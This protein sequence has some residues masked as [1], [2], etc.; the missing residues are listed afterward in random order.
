MRVFVTGA[1]GFIGG[2]IARVLAAR[3][4]V[5][6][7]SRSAAGDEVVKKLGAVPVRADLLTLEPGQLPP[8]DAVVH[9]AA[10]VEPW[11]RREDYWRANVDG[12]DRVLAAAKAAGAHRFVHMS[13]EAVLWRG[14]HLRDVIETHPYPKRTPF[15][16]AETKA[17]A[18][19]RVVAA[20]APGFETIVLRPRFVWG[21][22]DRTIV[23]ET[24]AMVERGAFVWL[25]G[26]RARTSTTHVAN[27]A[28]AAALA[29]DKGRAGEIYFV[30]DG[31]T[32]DFKTFLTRLLGANG[33]TLPERSLPSWLVRPLAAVI[34]TAWRALGPEG[35]PPLTRHAVGLMACDCTVRDDKARRELGYKPVIGVEQGLR[36]LAGRT[37]APA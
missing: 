25:D 8:C 24:R 19:R 14:Q 11:G 28:H 21:P 26:G 15:L 30:T 37:S 13:T 1:T 5:L 3:H 35:P 7:M 16:Y 31:E 2:E 27:L 12:T 29:L 4:T 6:A 23:P 34:E 22:G 20:N 36:E 33:V 18:E 32:T 10:W 17:E 9:C